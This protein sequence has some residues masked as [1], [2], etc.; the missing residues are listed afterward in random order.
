MVL[1]WDA[2]EEQAFPRFKGG[3]GT[4]YGKMVFDGMN[5]MLMAR[6]APGV[7]IGL[8]T[9]DTSSEIIHVLGGRARIIMDGVEEVVLP[10]QLHYCPKGHAHT[11][12]SDGGEELV[13]LAIVPEQ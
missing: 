7:S 13:M 2:M 9:H 10:G 3:E 5:R 8:H 4:T 12:I 1:N 6:L 11:T